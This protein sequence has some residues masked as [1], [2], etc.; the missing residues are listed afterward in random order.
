MESLENKLD[1]QEENKS[2][3]SNYSEL[4]EMSSFDKERQKELETAIAEH[5]A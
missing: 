2:I 3:P 5:K 1:L 4:K